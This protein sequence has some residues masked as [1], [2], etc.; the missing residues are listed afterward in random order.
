MSAVRYILKSGKKD[1]YVDLLFYHLHLRCYVVIDLKIDEFKPEYA[2]KMSFYLSAVDDL[3]KHPDDQASIGLILC[4]E[5]DR[6]V[7]EYS[8]RNTSRP[9]GVAEY[10]LLRKLP[11]NLQKELPSAKVI[12]EELTRRKDVSD[13]PS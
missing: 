3:M 11:K 9:V 12:S 6:I 1:F 7:V 10:R 2:G 4:K 5:K 13:K 8:L